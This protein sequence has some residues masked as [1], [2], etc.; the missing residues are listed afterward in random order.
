M[1]QFLTPVDLESEGSPTLLEGEQPL[2]Q[3]HTGVQLLNEKGDP[4]ATGL[5]PP[6]RPSYLALSPSLLSLWLSLCFSLALTH[7]RM[8]YRGGAPHHV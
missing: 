3:P 8:N 4:M 5:P 7:G 2:G 1:A 6:A